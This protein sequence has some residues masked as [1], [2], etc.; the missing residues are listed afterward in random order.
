MSYLPSE[1]YAAL[2]ML[3]DDYIS[4]IP[5]ELWGCICEMRSTHVFVIDGNKPLDEQGLSEDAVAMIALLKLN[6]WCE[7][8]DEKTELLNLLYTNEE[9]LKERVASAANTRELMKIIKTHKADNN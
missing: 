2:T 3:G 7:T 5:Q 4:K 1:L 9:K 8:E 6:Y